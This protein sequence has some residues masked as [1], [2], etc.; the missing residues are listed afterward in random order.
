MTTWVLVRGLTREAGH[1]GAF[2]GDLAAALGAHH[3]VLA[4]DLPGAGELHGL[5]SPSEV[6]DM[7]LALRQEVAR[8]GAQGPFALVGLS[9]GAMAALEWADAA[10]HELVGC[11]LI[12]TSVGDLNP[13][14]Q[15]L[16]PR[17]YPRLLRIAL[18]PRALPREK[19]ILAMTSSQP[20]RHADVLPQWVALARKHPVSAGNALRQLWAASHY[21]LPAGKPDV[22]LLVLA[23]AGDGLVSPACS[24]RLAARWHLP[25]HLH[26]TAGHDLPLDDPQWVARQAAAW[27]KALYG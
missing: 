14:W 15:R 20:G 27:W 9:L 18:D 25:S 7:A 10:P 4:V 1:W 11:V 23:S 2:T 17:N 3:R 12:N 13:F 21:Q 5:R 24:K 19:R 8:R 22:P 16:R 26:L 6:A